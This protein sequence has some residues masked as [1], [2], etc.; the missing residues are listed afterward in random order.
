[1]TATAL[2]IGE[3]ARRSGFTPDTLRYYERVGLLPRPER[4]PSGRRAYDDRSVDRLRFV[5]RA[6]GLGCSLNEIA[7]LLTAFDDACGDVQAPLRALI[8]AKVIDARHR[9]A[10]LVALTAQLEKARAGLMAEPSAGPCNPGCACVDGPSESRPL[11]VAPLDR[12]EP[13]IACTLDHRQVTERAVE[14]QTVL[15]D[16]VDRT[17]IPGGVRLALRPHVDLAEI[18]RLARAEWVCCSFYTFAITVDGRGMALE[19]TAPAE[20]RPLVDSLFGGGS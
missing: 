12:P 10:E 19:V 15:A 14:W 20:A 1:M 16:V 3:L 5:A 18:G 11:S 9:A 2:A 8:D 6:K 7:T 17:A 4:T 13:A